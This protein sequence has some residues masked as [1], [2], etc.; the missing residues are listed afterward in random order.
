MRKLLH[1]ASTEGVTDSGYIFYGYF[2]K[3]CCNL[4]QLINLTFLLGCI[5]VGVARLFGTILI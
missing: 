2:G 4:L 1:P 5:L 3:E